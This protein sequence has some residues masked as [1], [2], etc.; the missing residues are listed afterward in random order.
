MSDCSHAGRVTLDTA[1]L[2]ALFFW[3]KQTRMLLRLTAPSVT[4]EE[5]ATAGVESD[6]VYEEVMEKPN[7]GDEE[8]RIEGF[9]RTMCSARRRALELVAAGTLPRPS[10][11]SRAAQPS[12]SI[13]CSR[14][15]STSTR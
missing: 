11:Y 3:A 1:E 13:G 9:L 15:G 14:S 6:A 7:V 4:V 10:S 12:C 5:L 8:Q 2:R